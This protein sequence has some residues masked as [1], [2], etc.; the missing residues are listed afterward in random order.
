MR[1]QEGGVRDQQRHH[2]DAPGRLHREEE[3][4][5]RRAIDHDYT[6][7]RPVCQ[8][9]LREGHGCQRGQAER[10]ERGK[11]EIHRRRHQHRRHGRPR[12][13]RHQRGL[14][15][16]DAPG[17]DPQDGASGQ[18]QPGDR[19]RQ[20]RRH[21]HRPRGAPPV[22]QR[23]AEQQQ[24]QRPQRELGGEPPIANARARRFEIGVRELHR[25]QRLAGRRPD[26]DGVRSGVGR[27]F[28]RESERDRDNARL[29]REVGAGHRRPAVARQ[30]RLGH[31]RTDV[32]GGI[33][34]VH[35]RLHA[36]QL[37]ALRALSQ[38][39][40]S[41]S[42]EPRLGNILRTADP[43]H[44]LVARAVDGDGDRVGRGAHAF[45]GQVEQPAGRR[46]I[47]LFSQP[48][49]FRIQADGP[50]RHIEAVAQYDEL[51]RHLGLQAGARGG[52]VGP[53]L[54]A[55]DHHGGNPDGHGSHGSAQG[56]LLGASGDEGREDHPHRHCRMWI[57]PAQPVR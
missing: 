36:D 8:P 9:P 39:Q 27:T 3:R 45:A 14:G 51:P 55:L 10:H 22:E 19:Q 57:C 33:G 11:Q 46:G 23:P 54:R 20:R 42:G 40:G 13:G 15:E 41:R 35:H 47:A 2:R 1:P 52:Q 34:G 37:Q 43:G 6:D 28:E 17:C 38:K 56:Q 44:R 7:A 25:R 53:E 32:T 50:H 5:Q 12:R 49:G 31:D 16:A 24:Q 4:C 26:D 18:Q 48:D 29:E 30:R 21:G